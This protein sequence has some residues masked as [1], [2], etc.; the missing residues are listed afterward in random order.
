MGSIHEVIE[1]LRQEPTNSER[2]W[3]ASD[4]ARLAFPSAASAAVSCV[5]ARLA[6]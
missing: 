6:S 4:A 2:G 3:T 1:A 5:R